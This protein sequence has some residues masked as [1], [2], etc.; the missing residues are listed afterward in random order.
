VHGQSSRNAWPAQNDVHANPRHNAANTGR[1]RI[2]SNPGTAA[3]HWTVNGHG[4]GDAS[5][6]AAPAQKDVMRKTIAATP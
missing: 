3:R 2:S 5:A 6:A 1:R 4:T